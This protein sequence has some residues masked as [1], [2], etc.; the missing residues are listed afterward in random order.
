MDWASYQQSIISFSMIVKLV[1]IPFTT[2]Q[3]QL[4]NQR[5]TSKKI[6]ALYWVYSV[7]SHVWVKSNRRVG[8]E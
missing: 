2:A 7:Y 4:D 5:K 6:N 8:S 3:R 1:K